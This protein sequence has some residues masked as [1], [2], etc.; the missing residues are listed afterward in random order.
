L[1]A[2][3]RR[4]SRKRRTTA[5]LPPDLVHEGAVEAARIYLEDLGAGGLLERLDAVLVGRSATR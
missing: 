3:L 4:N 1:T 5:V 2:A